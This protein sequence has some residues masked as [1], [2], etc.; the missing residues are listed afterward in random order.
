M[1]DYPKRGRNIVL[2][3]NP[4]KSTSGVTKYNIRVTGELLAVLRSKD[5]S[6]EDGP[7]W[8]QDPATGWWVVGYTV[9]EELVSAAAAD[10]ECKSG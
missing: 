1:S 4:D 3:Q 7:G 6:S 8:R 5:A 9:D 10:T 2:E